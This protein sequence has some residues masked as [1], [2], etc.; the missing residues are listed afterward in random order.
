[1]NTYYLIKDKV[2]YVL[3]AKDS[4][5][6]AFLMSLK[7]DEFENFILKD[8]PSM[9]AVRRYILGNSSISYMK[10]TTVMR[11]KAT[12][13]AVYACDNADLS[14]ARIFKY[15]TSDDTYR[16][17]F[18]EWQDKGYLSKRKELTGNSL[19]QTELDYLTLKMAE[20][21]E[22]GVSGSHDSQKRYHLL[23]EIKKIR[24]DASHESLSEDEKDIFLKM[25][26]IKEKPFNKLTDQLNGKT[27]ALGAIS[28][29]AAK[30]LSENGI[31][32]TNTNFR[33]WV[34]TPEDRDKLKGLVQDFKRDT[35]S[36]ADFHVV[37]HPKGDWY[38]DKPVYQCLVKI[39]AVHD[40]V[41]SIKGLMKG[42]VNLSGS[43]PFRGLG[44]NDRGSMDLETKED[45]LAYLDK[46]SGYELVGLNMHM[47]NKLAQ[48]FTEGLPQ[49]GARLFFNGNFKDRYEREI[50]GHLERFTP[51]DPSLTT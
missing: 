25:A 32:V 40:N 50:N 38:D 3:T 8:Y 22:S 34:E 14:K 49:H 44:N 37:Y 45:M 47:D 10:A 51:S 31:D 48:K 18:L 35:G 26:S 16:L 13:N 12:P 33:V 15:S 4:K 2:H 20:V 5:D 1:M 36:K 21:S 6:A 39:C 11:S 19:S 17:P 24:K 7:E 9:D 46:I 28:V 27:K 43:I 41:K 29:D 42:I 23:K 30:K